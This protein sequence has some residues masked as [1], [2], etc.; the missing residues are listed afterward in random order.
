MTRDAAGAGLHRYLEIERRLL[1]H[2]ARR[3]WG[4][5]A[6]DEDAE[7]RFFEE[8]ED[9]AAALT[10]EERAAMREIAIERATIRPGEADVDVASPRSTGHG[11]RRVARV[12]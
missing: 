10:P 8:L 4:G 9:A 2:R 3:W 6:E 5:L 1:E 12:A 11:P 7:A